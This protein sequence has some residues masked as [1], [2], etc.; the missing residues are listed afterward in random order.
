MQSNGFRV[1]GT[2]IELERLSS[3]VIERV[4]AA[5]MTR[6]FD[7]RSVPEE[8]L[9]ELCSD[10]NDYGL[11]GSGY[12]ATAC[13]HRMGWLVYVVQSEGIP[14]RVRKPVEAAVA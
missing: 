1:G 12:Y 7:G 2:E 6:T 10:C 3:A 5:L 13:P 4:N 8:A 11:I 9:R 14:C